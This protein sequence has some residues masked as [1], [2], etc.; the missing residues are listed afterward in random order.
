MKL[1]FS[2]PGSWSFVPCVPYSAAILLPNTTFMHVV[3]IHSGF[4][5]ILLLF[6]D[7]IQIKKVLEHLNRCIASL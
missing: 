7:I 1:M 2:G 3:E 5:I 6:V 4:N